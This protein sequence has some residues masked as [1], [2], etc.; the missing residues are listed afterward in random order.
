MSVFNYIIYP[1][2]SLF[3]MYLVAFVFL[4]LL[5]TL[6]VPTGRELWKD[7]LADLRH[8]YHHS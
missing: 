3:D 1:I 4:Y 6:M 7:I 8:L 2:L 5:G